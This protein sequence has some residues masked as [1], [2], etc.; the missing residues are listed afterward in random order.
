MSSS[1]RRPGANWN[2]AKGGREV[3]TL[4]LYYT[5]IR[6]LEGQEAL[7]LPLLTPARRKRA[8]TI[9]VVRDRLHCVGAGLLLRRVLGVTKDDD[10]CVGEQGKLSLAGEGPCF[11][12]SHGGRY[13][14]LAVFPTAVG[15]DVEPIADRLT[16]I[17]RRYLH[18]EELAWL[19]A[20]P[21]PARFAHLWTRVESALKADG[22]GLA[23]DRRDFSVL[24]SGRPWFLETTALEGHVL[25]CAA[26]EPFAMELIHL[27]A[28]QLLK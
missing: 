21:T 11:N 2:T 28:A 25:S 12:L 6:E 7:A 23:I 18:P 13:A 3:A 22:R 10:L 27:P 14:V 16:V 4:K 5:D 26:G 1:A 9:R 8:E 20:D 19:E 15:V 17:P 24:D